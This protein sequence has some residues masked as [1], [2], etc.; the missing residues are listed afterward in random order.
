MEKEET[1]LENI[2]LKLT[3]EA[4][5]NQQAQKTDKKRGKGAERDGKY[6]LIDEGEQNGTEKTDETEEKR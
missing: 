6:E 1:S 5:K 3:A 2:F 4:E